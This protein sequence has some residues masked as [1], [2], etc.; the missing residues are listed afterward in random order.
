MPALLFWLCRAVVVVTARV[1]TVTAIVSRDAVAFVIVV[2]ASASGSWRQAALGYS[3][4]LAPGSI[5]G[6]TA[7]GSQLWLVALPPPQGSGEAEGAGE[8]WGGA[9]LPGW[10]TGRSRCARMQLPPAPALSSLCFLFSS[11][12]LGTRPLYVAQGLTRLPVPPMAGDFLFIWCW[13]LRARGRN[14]R[15]IWWCHKT[16]VTQLS[17]GIVTLGL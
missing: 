8:Q 1:A 13:E 9:A 4:S 6:G 2:D 10:H 7:L 3:I 16:W 17:V 11:F 15:G 14:C 12:D 5:L